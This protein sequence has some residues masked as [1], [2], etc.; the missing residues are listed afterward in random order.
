M[1]KKPGR[2]LTRLIEPISA[3]PGGSRRSDLQG[4]DDQAVFGT[5]P[6]TLGPAV[7]R[8]QGI[9]FPS[10]PRARQAICVIVSSSRFAYNSQT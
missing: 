6:A 7:R 4:C 1:P 10:R 8:F 9:S 2:P 3:T 5:G